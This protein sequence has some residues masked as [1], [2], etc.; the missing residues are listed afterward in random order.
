[1]TRSYLTQSADTLFNEI[2]E[3]I[4]TRYNNVS[5]AQWTFLQIED[6]IVLLRDYIRRSSNEFAL[7]QNELY[8]NFSN[9]IHVQDIV[10]VQYDKIDRI[11]SDIND[12][13]YTMHA[14]SEHSN[15]IKH[16]YSNTCNLLYTRGYNETSNLLLAS[17]NYLNKELIRIY[18]NV[19]D[20]GNNLFI[21]FPNYLQYKNDILFNRA[22]NIYDEIVP[23]L[24]SKIDELNTE[25]VAEGTSNF[26]YNEAKFDEMF[27]TLTNDH[28]ADGNTNRWI[29]NGT[30]A[31][32]LR[33]LGTLY[34][35]NI[36]IDGKVSTISTDIYQSGSCKIASSNAGNLLNI[37]NTVSDIFRAYDSDNRTVLY[38]NNSNVFM[39]NAFDGGNDSNDSNDNLQ[40]S[41]V[42]YANIFQ[43]YAKNIQNITLYDRNTDLLPEGSNLY[44]TDD[45]VANLIAM[46]NINTSNYILSIANN[47][48]EFVQLNS[49][50]LS[51]SNIFN[52]AME[53]NDTSNYLHQSVADISKLVIEE[54]VHL[55]DYVQNISNEIMGYFSM[56][57]FAT[58]N[59][60]LQIMP[61]ALS[62][63]NGLDY[64]TSNYI[65][66]VNAYI[67]RTLPTM[68]YNE[69]ISNYISRT[70]NELGLH[71]YNS[72]IIQDQSNYLH[73][74]CNL[75]YQGLL[76]INTYL[77][78]YGT[79]TS[80]QLVMMMKDGMYGVGG[81]GSVAGVAG[82][83]GAYD[84][85][86]ST[87]NELMNYAYNML[88]NL[89]LVTN[90]YIMQDVYAGDKI[91]QSNFSSYESVHVR[92][93][94]DSDS[95]VALDMMRKEGFVVHFVFKSKYLVDTPI[96]RLGGDSISVIDIKILYGFLYVSIGYKQ[97]SVSIFSQKPIVAETWYTADIVVYLNNGNKTISFKMFLN[98]VEQDI[99]MISDFCDSRLM[100]EMH[101]ATYHNSMN[102]L[103]LVVA[104]NPVI[105]P[106]N[107]ASGIYYMV[108]D[109][110]AITYTVSFTNNMHC[111]IL[112][113]AG[114]GGGGYN[115]GGG[116]G[117]GA[118][119]YNANYLFNAGTYTFK[120]GNGGNGGRGGNSNGES[121]ISPQN[122][123][124]TCISFGG[125]DVLRCKGGG[126]GGSYASGYYTGGNGGCGGGGLGWD[127]NFLGERT[128]VGGSANNAGTAGMGYSG[129]SGFNAF[130]KTILSGGGGGGIGGAGQSATLLQKEGGNGGDGLVFN[131]RGRD[132]VLGGGGGGGE[133]SISTNNPAGLGGGANLNGNFIRVGGKA[134]R[135]EGEMG[136]GGMPNTGSG[137][138]SGRNASGGAGGSGIIILQYTVNE[139]LSMTVGTSNYESNQGYLSGFFYTNSYYSSNYVYQYKY[140]SNISAWD[141]NFYDNADSRLGLATIA[142]LDFVQTEVI[143]SVKF[144]TGYYFFILDLQNEIVA[145]LFIGDFHVARL[146]QTTA[147]PLYIVDGYYRFYLKTLRSIENR[148]IKYIIPRYKYMQSWD[149]ISYNLNKN[150]DI[151]YDQ[152]AL[153]NTQNDF[154]LFTGNDKTSNML[155][156]QE[157]KIVGNPLT[158][159]TDHYIKNVLK[160]RKIKD[161]MRCTSTGS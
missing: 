58:S 71:I 39:G 25:L 99:I 145:D 94:N 93:Y 15:Q 153:A 116:G 148:N 149:G 137:G 33:I 21:N 86:R 144:T 124:D 102:Y 109:N 37:T 72:T 30:Y 75:L 81:A 91:L 24:N 121:E 104:C 67:S 1:M 11:Y 31:G 146:S 38:V 52:K 118:Y 100:S 35:S 115:Y 61:D 14:S 123:E 34:A 103:Y 47:A 76:R 57:D 51:E 151:I 156:L 5:N 106:A 134:G 119:Y 87:S 101:V 40:I 139:T 22:Y 64:D 62:L 155:H 44:L 17:S 131:I 108:F 63:L 74:T 82:V 19:L 78:D 9:S 120:V 79:Q 4:Y 122:G 157:I 43:G 26:Y 80:N 130:G 158:T 42:I 7:Y 114:G 111:K 110:P 10:N 55:Y 48:R 127:R 138:G 59:Y 29:V 142:D 66:S 69:N 12:F 65:Q 28:I 150:H 73:I 107:L 141:G 143:A 32:N 56:S 70:S 92:N 95:R 3:I 46:S 136:T 41:G 96:Y 147:N 84:Y 49:Y 23:N 126:H 125:N 6:D 68:V 152:K 135:N 77:Q 85:L 140:S 159:G 112:M 88:S 36:V 113:I 54:D 90:V 8:A 132:E 16:I 2:Q 105:A 129:G 89:N 53:Y 97:N 27:S 83:G 18:V 160:S 98:T 161:M 117:A 128:Y 60:L 13:M 133:W 20:Y 154:Q 45:R 50:I